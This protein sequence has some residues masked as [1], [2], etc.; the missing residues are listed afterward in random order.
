MGYVRVSTVLQ[1]LEQQEALNAAGVVKM[2]SDTMSGARDDRPGLAALMEY[3]RAGDT[4]VVWK[5]DRLGRNLQHILETVKTLTERGVTLVSVTD[6]I[7]SSTAAGRMKIGVL[8]SLAEY[9]RELIKERT[10]LKRAAS[11]AN[12]IKFGRHKRVDDPSH[13]ATA[14]R[15]KADG[16]HSQGHRQIPRRQPRQPL[17]LTG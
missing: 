5:L 1:T 4:V 16:Q 14:K 3:V 7:D 15:M 12:G 8:G 2:F 17:S 13:L 6:G 9:E 10:A 11:R